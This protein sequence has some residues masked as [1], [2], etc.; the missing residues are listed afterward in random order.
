MKKEAIEIGATYLAKVGRRS[1]EVRIE[2]ELARGG[3]WEATSLASNKKIRIKSAQAI[4]RPVV[5]GT[6][7]AADP[8]GPASDEPRLVTAVDDALVPLTA[9]EKETKP[10]RKKGKALKAKAA[11]TPKEKK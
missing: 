7:D 9:L 5:Q 8:Q 2:R 3:G 11:K 6:P 4:S 1:M 10:K